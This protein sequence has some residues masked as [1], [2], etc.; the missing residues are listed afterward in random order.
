MK[1]GIGVILIAL[2]LCVSLSV[3]ATAGYFY[4]VPDDAYYAEA[5]AWAVDR[6]IVNGTSN[7]EFSPKQTCTQAQILTFL[8]RSENEPEP[9][10]S[11]PFTDILPEKYYYKAAIW[12]YEKGMVAG[13]LFEPNTPCTRSMTATYLWNLAGSPAVSNDVF[14][15]VPASAYYAQ[16]VAWAVE[17]GIT[18]GTTATTFSPNS[19]CTRGQIVTFLH[20]YRMVSSGTNI[21]VQDSVPEQTV[22]VSYYPKYST[23]PDFGA[24]AGIS[25]VLTPSDATSAAYL[26]EI[27]DVVDAGRD[28][29]NRYYDLLIECGF[30]YMGSFEGSDGSVLTFTD[31]INSVAFGD[32]DGY[33]SVMVTRK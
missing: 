15:D 7:T 16:A 4:D 17:K 6:G 32:M 25:A 5:V 30:E 9:T 22:S 12:A 11:N 33:F 28:I 23:V 24:F 26:Y 13:S 31:G 2:S 21:P 8:W 19:V 27:A 10:I 1:K 20:R 29:L 3:T 14:S 18:S